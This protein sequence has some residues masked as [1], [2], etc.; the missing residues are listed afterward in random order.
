MAH[1]SDIP[2]PSL[3]NITNDWAA[4]SL[5]D[6]VSNLSASKVYLF[7]GTA[8]NTVKAAVMA[9]LQ[10]YYRSFVPVANT[11]YNNA[12][13]S[14]HAM[15]TDDFGGHCPTTAPP[16]INDCDFDLAGDM[17][18]HLH[19]RLNPRNNGKLSGSLTAFDQRA[20]ISGHGMAT[21]GWVY[22][23][24]ACAAGATCKLHVVFHGCKQNTAAVDQQ[25]VLHAGYNRWADTNNIVIL[26]PQTSAAAPNG[27][28]DWWG[29]DSA[30]FARKSGPQMAA[31]KAMVDR[32]SGMVKM[33]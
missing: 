22:I 31:V 9:D 10:A 8:D 16:F 25:F 20:F 19:G 26:Y 33:K 4:G 6:P 7:S 30:D 13:P 2:I 17:L 11:F 28:W 27:C 12:I 14:G 24:Q 29:Y 3:V 18:K 23:P 5:I 32:L 21:T 15:I 1:S